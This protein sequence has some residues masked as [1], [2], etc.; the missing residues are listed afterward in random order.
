MKKILLITYYWPPSGGVGVLRW[1][2]MANELAKMGYSITVLHPKHA[3]YPQIDL[4]LNEQLHSTINELAVPIFE[5][6]QI[7][8]KIRPNKETSG[9]SAFQTSKNPLQNLVLHIRANYFIPDARMFWITPASKFLKTHLAKE[10][11]NFIISNGPPHTCHVIGYNAKQTLPSAK[12]IADFRDPWQEIDYF[13]QLPLTKQKRK[14]HTQLEQKIIQHADVITTVSPSWKT[15]FEKK[16]AKRVEYFT[17]GF[18]SKLFSTTHAKKTNSIFTIRHIGSIDESRNPAQLWNVLK[19]YSSIHVELVGNVSKKI[20]DDV[21][22]ID[23][24]SIIEQVSH[25]KAIQNMQTSDALLLCNSEVGAN[26]GRIPA[27]LFEYIGAKR[28]ILYFGRLDNDAAQIIQDY[29]LGI[30]LSYDEQPEVIQKALEQ[31]QKFQLPTANSIQQFSREEIT[32]Q[33]SRFL[34]EL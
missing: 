20:Q 18:S 22:G 12:W 7:L 10:S 33:F 27:K 19:Q 9:N 2:H 28:P 24:I 6:Q 23:T 4:Q 17:N 13:A 14:K 34:N 21:S 1:L 15:L 3:V 31:I 25:H 16:G 8:N 11:Y 5:P 32:A 26:K 29:A 30:C